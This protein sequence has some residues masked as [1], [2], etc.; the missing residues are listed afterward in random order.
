MTC[1][2]AQPIDPDA[3]EVGSPAA[4]GVGADPGKQ[5]DDGGPIDGT[6]QTQPA[7]P[8]YSSEITELRGK[9]QQLESRKAEVGRIRNPQ[10]RT[11]TLRVIRDVSSRYERRLTELE[12]LVT[13]VI[14]PELR[15]VRGY[16]SEGVRLARRHEVSIKEHEVSIKDLLSRVESL[17]ALVATGQSTKADPANAAPAEQSQPSGTEET[18]DQTTTK[19][20]GTVEGEQDVA[21]QDA[22]DPSVQP[23]E[24]TSGGEN[25]TPSQPEQ[26]STATAW[27]VFL[28][29]L[30]WV[31]AL[32]VIAGVAYFG[33]KA[34]RHFQSREQAE[35]GEQANT[36]QPVPEPAVTDEV[37]QAGDQTT[38]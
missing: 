6:P 21:P 25:Q 1:A 12:R 22:P 29:V 5:V 19:P 13:K 32:T 7:T 3:S 18:P 17:E 15:R 28:S 34:Y 8:D 23:E 35:A 36:L 14:Q 27:D 38:G 9:I 11:R 31:A 30:L 33:Y 2:F 26:S 10:T 37:T 16:A 20:S 24:G 4:H